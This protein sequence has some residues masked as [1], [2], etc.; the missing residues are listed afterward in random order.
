MEPRLYTVLGYT[1][2][3]FYVHGV[4]VK[5]IVKSICGR[6]LALCR[7]SFPGQLSCLSSYRLQP[8]SLK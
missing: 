1:C 8:P 7:S 6:W 2:G 5:L 3:E 4:P